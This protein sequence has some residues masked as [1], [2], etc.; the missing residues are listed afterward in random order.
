M[1]DCGPAEYQRRLLGGDCEGSDI[2]E[3]EMPC[4]RTG[5]GTTCQDDPRRPEARRGRN[6]GAAFQK[7]LKKRA[8]TELNSICSRAVVVIVLEPFAGV[9]SALI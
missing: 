5:Y 4:L 7:V 2:R 9:K 8:A 1:D 3:E 6:S